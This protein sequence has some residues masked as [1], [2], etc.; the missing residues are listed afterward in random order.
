[1]SIQELIE[2]LQSIM[3]ESGPDATIIFDSVDYTDCII[4]VEL[5]YDAATGEP[6]ILLKGE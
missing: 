6:D 2:R 1:M 4:D 3:K 5:S